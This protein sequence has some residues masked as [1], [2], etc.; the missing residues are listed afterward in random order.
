MID[1]VSFCCFDATKANIHFKYSVSVIL[2]AFIIYLIYT[3]ISRFYASFL[4]VGKNL[5]RRC[6]APLP[7]PVEGFAFLVHHGSTLK[8]Q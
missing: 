2:A 4:N 8:R 6:I 1:L 3:K 5:S 7:W